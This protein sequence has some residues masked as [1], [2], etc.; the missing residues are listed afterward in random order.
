MRYT[1]RIYHDRQPRVGDTVVAVKNVRGYRAGDELVVVDV[2]SFTG[3]C[4]KAYNPRSYSFECIRYIHDNW[5]RIFE[6]LTHD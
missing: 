2:K 1:E 3:D 6:E 4:I 5:Y